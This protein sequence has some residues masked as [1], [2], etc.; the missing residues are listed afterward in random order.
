MVYNPRQR[1]STARRKLRKRLK[2][3]GRG[4]WIC[5]AFGRN[6]RIDYELPPGHPMSFE[7]DELIPVSKWK[8]GGYSSPTA[9]ALDY[10]NLDAAH[11][12]CNQWRGNKSVQEVL[13]IARGK[14]GRGVQDNSARGK[15]SQGMARVISPDGLPQPWKF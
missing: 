8:E 2:A 13:A 14:R 10:S 5:R 15:V 3:E 4:C 6:P 11:K 1:N 9:A 12:R 7:V